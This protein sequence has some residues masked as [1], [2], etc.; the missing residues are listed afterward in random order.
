[1]ILDIGIN[2]LHSEFDKN[3]EYFSMQ[4][5]L[6]KTIVPLKNNNFEIALFSFRT[7]KAALWKQCYLCQKFPLPIPFHTWKISCFE[8]ILHACLFTR[9][10]FGTLSM[11]NSSLLW[12]KALACKTISI[13]T[14]IVLLI[15]YAHIWEP[16]GTLSM[17][18]HLTS[19]RAFTFFP[20]FPW[21][22][23]ND[24]EDNANEHNMVK[25]P[26]W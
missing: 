18:C 22:V 8:H 25:N 12:T 11:S 26:N 13:V 16:S 20:V 10:S 19:A 7:L 5:R 3:K 23:T 4:T 17:P 9:V 6:T 2:K 14:L 1:M 21:R 24:E 15:T